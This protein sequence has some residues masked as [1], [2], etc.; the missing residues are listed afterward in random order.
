MMYSISSPAYCVRV[1][2]ISNFTYLLGKV[3][4]P[5]SV[6]D[7]DCSKQGVPRISRPRGLEDATREV[8]LNNKCCRQTVSLWRTKQA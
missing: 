5:V 6:R 1:A 7:K 8:R 3:V 2:E 4:S